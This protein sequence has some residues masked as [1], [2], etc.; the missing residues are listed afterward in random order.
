ML[1]IYLKVLICKFILG[2]VQMTI[3]QHDLALVESQGAYVV[4]DSEGLIFIK[5]LIMFIITEVVRRQ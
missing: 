2:D 3:D 4:D 5:I 1:L